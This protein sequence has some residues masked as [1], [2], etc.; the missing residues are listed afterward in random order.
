MPYQSVG[1]QN[2]FTSHRQDSYFGL[3]SYESARELLFEPD[4]QFDYQQHQ[5]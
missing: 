3:N 4:F 1:F 5:A 2:A